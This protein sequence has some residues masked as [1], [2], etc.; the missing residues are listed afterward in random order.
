MDCVVC[1]TRPPAY[2]DSMMCGPCFNRLR[3]D[4]ATLVGAYEWLGISMRA[5]GPAWKTGTIHR[6]GD[7][8]LPFRTDLFD[9]REDIAGKLTSW[10]RAV[11]EEHVPA[12]RGPAD[13]E[14]RTVGRWLI[15]QLPWI[16]DQPWCD[17]M[18]AELGDA[19]RRA[20]G[21]APWDRLRRDLPLPCPGCGLLSLAQH[22]GDEQVT[23][24]IRTC[25][26]AMPWADYWR[27]VVE[28]S[29]KE[30]QEREERQAAED[31]TPPVITQEGV[32]A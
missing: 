1:A 2:T 6:S 21:L 19:A 3:A 9:A 24:R 11:A 12:L 5:P 22:G 14:P 26:H 20:Y 16:S 18:A 7:P 27:L 25:G 10:A 23:C 28:A 32:A 8:R 15:A 30:R 31:E 4:I 29:E 17:A 13:G